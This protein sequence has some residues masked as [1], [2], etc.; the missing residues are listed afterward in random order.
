M[1]ILRWVVVKALYQHRPEIF[2][3]SVCACGGTCV[4]VLM[5]AWTLFTPHHLFYVSFVMIINS[6]GLGISF[7]SPHDRIIFTST[8]LQASF[9]H[10]KVQHVPSIWWKDECH[11]AIFA[12][13][14]ALKYFNVH[15]MKTCFILLKSFH[16][17]SQCIIHKAKHMP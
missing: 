13:K 6:W 4:R 5:L 11:S 15:P 8:V 16:A 10:I 1:Y 9:G 17:E 14:R 12:R 3:A 7:C 2:C